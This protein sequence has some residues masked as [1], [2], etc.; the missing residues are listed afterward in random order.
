M[1]ETV[2]TCLNIMRR[3]PPSTLEQNLSALVSLV[4]DATEQLLQCIDQPLQVATDPLNGRAFLMCD[5]NR[6]GDSYRSP[7]SNKYVPD[8]EDGFS[9]SGKLREVEVEANELFDQYRELYFMGGISSVY[10]W[11]VDSGFAGCWLLKKDVTAGRFVK[12]GC[13]DSIH[14]IETHDVGS[15][16]AVYKLTTTVMLSMIVEKEVVGAVNLSGSL[17][18][19]AEKNLPFVNAA[20]HLRNMGAMIEEMEIEIR[21]NMDQLYI[22]K[23]REVV[24]AIRRAAVVPAGSQALAAS[25]K[26]AV[27]RHGERRK[28]M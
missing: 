9:P 3:M 17:S 8:L 4:P 14:V 13:W 19:Q 6:D 11:D 22:S 24:G 2:T 26:E 21:M 20:S 16:R 1:E 12:S 23:T 18:R 28:P 25:L 7:W 27:A 5:Y 10:L 15:G